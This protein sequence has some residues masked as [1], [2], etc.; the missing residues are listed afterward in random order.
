[1]LRKCSGWFLIS[2]SFIPFGIAILEHGL[3]QWQQATVLIAISYIMFY[4]GVFLVGKKVYQ[5][6]K[7]MLFTHRFNQPKDE[8]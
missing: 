4:L 8:D 2:S 3:N 7:N 1:M 6:Y 5:K